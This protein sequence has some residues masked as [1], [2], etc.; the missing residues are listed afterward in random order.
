MATELPGSAVTV[1][2]MSPAGWRRFQQITILSALSWVLACGS[3]SDHSFSPVSP[4][5]NPL[6]AEYFVSSQQGG[7]AR[8]EFGTDTSYGRQTSWFDVAPGESGIA[9]LVA[10]MK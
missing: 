10:G 5:D 9:I 8:V 1:L 6:V 7:R 2:K 3:A 4:T